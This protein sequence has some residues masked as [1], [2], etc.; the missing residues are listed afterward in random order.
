MTNRLPNNFLVDVGLPVYNEE[1]CLEENSL[2]LADYLKREANFR[3]QITIL[4]NAST[5][6]TQAIG[7]KLAAENECINYTRLPRKGKGYAVKSFMLSS[8]GDVIAFMDIDLSTKLRHFKLLVEGIAAGHEISIGTRLA[9]ES[10]VN[11][12]RMRELT[13]RVYNGLRKLMFR[14]KFSDAACGFKAIRQDVARAL[15]PIIQDDT[16][17]FDAEMLLLAEHF[18]MQIFEVPVE[19]E[20]DPDSK[21]RLP[22]TTR[23]L[24]GGLIRMRFS[25]KKK[26]IDWNKDS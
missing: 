11:R 10:K 8:P 6:E 14:S 1:S 4:D 20:E 15:A 17:F 2:V 13:S 5:D 9:K 16:W 7:E 21:V 25:I 3:W 19:W 12:S 22:S 24:V 26:K 18:K 23:E